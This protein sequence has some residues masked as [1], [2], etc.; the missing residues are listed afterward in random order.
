MLRYF[1]VN[2]TLAA[3][4]S[5]ELELRSEILAPP[6]VNKSRGVYLPRSS[7]AREIFFFQIS[8]Q[9]AASSALAAG[10]LPWVASILPHPARRHSGR[11]GAVGPHTGPS[12]L[13]PL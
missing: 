8:L 12:T 11:R 4:K 1:P 2:L 9:G 10:R 5:R 13:R 7:G 6:P 3:T